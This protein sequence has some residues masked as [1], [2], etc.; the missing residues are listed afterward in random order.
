MILV[1][2]LMLANFGIS[3]VLLMALR[4]IKKLLSLGYLA[5]AAELTLQPLTGCGDALSPQPAG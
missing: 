5:L 2:E 4:P 3:W 1:S